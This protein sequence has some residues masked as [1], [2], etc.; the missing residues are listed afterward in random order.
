MVKTTDKSLAVRGDVVRYTS[1]VTNSGSLPL[2]GVVFTDDIPAGT[3]FIPG[4]VSI[5]GLPVPNAD[6]AA[7]FPLTDMIPNQSVIVIFEVRII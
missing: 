7:G 1:I 2:S 4:S 5:D 6:P 3:E